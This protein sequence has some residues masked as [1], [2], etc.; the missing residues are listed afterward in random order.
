LSN[1]QRKTG[2]K[3]KGGQATKKQNTADRLYTLAFLFRFGLHLRPGEYGLALKELMGSL[4]SPVE[5]PT[6]LFVVIFI[7]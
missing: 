4:S 1:Q 2:Q 6:L 5:V 3:C 7:P